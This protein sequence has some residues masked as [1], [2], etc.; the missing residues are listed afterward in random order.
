[1]ANLFTKNQAVNFCHK[2]LHLIFC[3]SHR[4]VVGFSNRKKFLFEADMGNVELLKDICVENY[5]WV[6]FEG[7]RYVMH[8]VKG[9][10]NNPNYAWKISSCI[11]PFRYSLDLLSMFWRPAAII[12]PR[13]LPVFTDLFLFDFKGATTPPHKSS[14]LVFGCFSFFIFW[15]WFLYQFSKPLLW[16]NIKIILGPRIK[17]PSSALV[18][19]SS[20][21]SS[22]ANSYISIVL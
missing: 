9:K 5:L 17:L 7:N 10:G 15:K 11:L 3:S 21:T 20:S 6:H 19:G 22:S 1:M 2:V 16:G 4:Y 8:S 14:S 13:N 18:C 12:W